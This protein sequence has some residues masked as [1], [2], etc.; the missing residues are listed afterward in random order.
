MDMPS[1]GE[2]PVQEIPRNEVIRQALRSAPTV[3]WRRPRRGTVPLLLALLTIASA[4]VSAALA[5]DPPSVVA[6]VT[7]AVLAVAWALAVLPGLFGPRR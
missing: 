5:V 6:G 7:T 3:R 2:I 1:L 4:S